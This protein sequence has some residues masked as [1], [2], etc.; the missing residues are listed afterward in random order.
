LGLCHINYI[1]PICKQKIYVSRSFLEL[2]INRLPH[3]ELIELKDENRKVII[4]IIKDLKTG[5][6]K[7][8]KR[9]DQVWFP[10]MQYIIPSRRSE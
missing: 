8:R 4:Q 5:G 7:W 3:K 1:C 10:F 2:M 6:V 9:N